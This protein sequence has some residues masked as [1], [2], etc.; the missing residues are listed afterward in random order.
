MK[1]KYTWQVIPASI[2]DFLTNIDLFQCVCRIVW[3]L[4]VLLC[5]D[6][7]Q[8]NLHEKKTHA[9]QIVLAFY[10]K[11]TFDGSDGMFVK[12][13]QWKLYFLMKVRPWGVFAIRRLKFF[14]GKKP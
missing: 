14:V 11:Y 3:K 10:N 8:K 9:M 2:Y 5:V 12:L 13:Y 4:K 6:S 1:L 7:N